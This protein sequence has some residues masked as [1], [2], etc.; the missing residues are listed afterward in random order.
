MDGIRLEQ[1]SYRQAAS[2]GT[3]VRSLI[4]GKVAGACF[5]VGVSAR[6]VN[7]GVCVLCSVSE[8]G[9]DIWDCDSD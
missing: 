4:E 3:S 5:G 2:V 9:S 1:T 7:S 6:A 8:T